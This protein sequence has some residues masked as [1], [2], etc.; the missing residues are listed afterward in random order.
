MYSFT[1]ETNARNLDVIKIY[2]TNSSQYISLNSE[3]SAHKEIEK[4]GKQ[5]ESNKCYFIIGSGNGI[6]LQYLLDMNFNSKFY[7]IEIFDEIDYEESFKKKLH[8]Q[9][10]YFYHV[11]NLNYI[12]ISSA[13]RDAL[14]MN[15]EILIHP[16]YEKLNKELITPA[17]EKIKMGTTTA[18]INKNTERFFMFEWLTE[19]ILNLALSKKG[20]N[21]LDIK[22]HFENKPFILVA[23]GPSLIDNL[24][25]IKENKD[26]AYIIASG[27][28][29]NGLINEN[30]IPDFVTIIDASVVNFTA[31]FQNTKYN[32]PIITTGT[33]NHLILK[34]HQGEIYF[35]NL[36][37]DTITKEV[38]PEI[39]GIPTV[40]SVALYSLLLTHYLGA[41]EVFL[42]GQDLALNNGEYYAPGVHKHDAIK[43]LGPTKEVNGNYIN[44][45]V[46][47]LPLASTL[48]S[49]N[50][51]ISIIQ[52]VNNKI[53]IYNLS[54]IGAKIEG[55]SYK[56]VNEIQLEEIL[57]K[58]WIP[59]MSMEKSIDYTFSIEYLDKMKAC[60]E[61]V[62]EVL[63]K[64]DKM[65]TN[66]VTLH[67]LQKLLKLVKKL[68]ENDVLEKH[69]LNMIYSS[70]K[71]INNMFEYG[72]ENNFQTNS[73]RVE[74]LNK[75]KFF[76][77]YIQEYLDN[78]LCHHA[79]SEMK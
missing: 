31:H 73:E 59:Q 10:I 42:V 53:Q 17:I 64:I 1:K 37:Q 50:N 2:E 22:E 32:G 21:L 36:D 70:T 19:P 11:T 57:D 49:F 44:K 79:W 40:P 16:N 68:R 55:V 52:N 4:F 61:K 65:N 7:I 3:V 48:E 71:A 54:K 66:A 47:T 63:I 35:T 15:V 76:V 78:L 12:I 18:K 23:S 30:I 5:I 8:G 41:S 56:D 60:K 75:L 28:A 26:K 74:M 27:S 34:H 14:G 33:T 13:I 72:F 43:N 58:S 46:T 67:D 29:V 77:K 6:L 25:F 62:D 51:A 69:I 39:L 24:D 45:V 38:R 9:N 20:K